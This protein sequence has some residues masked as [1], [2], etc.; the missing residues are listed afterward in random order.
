MLIAR[1]MS[2]ANLLR[3]LLHR[4]GEPQYPDAQ[5]PGP[6]HR[7][8]IPGALDDAALFPPPSA[9]TA[10]TLSARAVFVDPH[11]GH[12][13]FTSFVIDRCNCSNF[14]SQLLHVYS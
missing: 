11:D 1:Q 13:A 10:K 3:P 6:P 9:P 7:P 5:G 12:F 2:D 14:A 4:H 8:H